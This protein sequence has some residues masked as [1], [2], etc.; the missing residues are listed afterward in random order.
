MNATLQRVATDVTTIKDT[1][2]ELKD[3]VERVQMRM[4]EAEQ[5]IMDLEEA[6]AEAGPKL[7]KCDKKVQALWS[8]VEELENR[9]RRNNIRIIG[10][11]EGSE[12]P[13]QM[14]QCV[15]KILSEALGFAG[16]EFEIE[17]AHRI[18][19]PIPDPGKA[20]RPVVVRFLRSSARDKI[21]RMAKE[22][23][24][25]D[26]EGGK[27]SLF[28]DVSKELAEKR[29]AFGPAKKRLRELQVKH[30][31]LYPATLVFTWNGQKKSFTDGKDVDRFL[32]QM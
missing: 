15:E 25:F 10:L 8:R 16:V 30:R 26:W 22:K 24:G 11:K 19:V 6:H 32:Q 9:S 23:R 29:K 4:A 28:E 3:S 2:R 27:L 20:P 1:T 7:D 18:P 12:L 14:D 17:R 13:G 5:R 31:M 21:I